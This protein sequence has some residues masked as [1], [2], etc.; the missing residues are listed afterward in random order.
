MNFRTRLI[1]TVVEI[2]EGLIFYPKLKKFYT[3]K[4]STQSS[5]TPII[6]DV[7]SNKGQSIDFFLKINP[8]CQIFGFEPN[9]SL[10]KKL[11]EKYKNNP[12]ITVNNLG[13]SSK[14]G[15]LIFQENIMDETSTFEPLNYDSEYLKKKAAVLGV[16]AEN[17]IVDRYEVEVTTLQSFLNEHSDSFIDVLKIDVEGHEY[18]CLLG[19]FNTSL[20]QYPIRFIQ[21]ESHNDD[22]YLSNKNHLGIENLLKTNGFEE[23]HKIKHGFGDFYEI[24][25]ENI[26]LS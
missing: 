8:L 5:K 20:K 25:Y 4:F 26:N 19:L 15:K 9:T 21:L 2:N 24:I 11:Q 16:S 6:I 13:V 12:K 7:G 1:Q 23:A 18:D 17:I 10:F 3:D 14:K 22:M